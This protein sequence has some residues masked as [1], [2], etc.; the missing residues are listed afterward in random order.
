MNFASNY[1]FISSKN[2][3]KPQPESLFDMEGSDSGS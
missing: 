3:S 1:A 2:K